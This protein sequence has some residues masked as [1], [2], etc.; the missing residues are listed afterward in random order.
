VE[1]RTARPKSIIFDVLVFLFHQL[2]STIGVVAIAACIALSAVPLL[3]SLFGLVDYQ[4]VRSALTENHLYPVQMLFA[5]LGGFLIARHWRQRSMLWVWIL[6]AATLLVGFVV[7]AHHLS[8]GDRLA[9]FFG[10]GC[11]VR[12][13]CFDQ[14]VFTLPLY[15]AVVYSLG[16][17]FGLRGY[18]R[19]SFA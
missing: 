1:A 14:L 17:W 10:S 15:T 16:A 19:K 7:A 8:P 13:G 4:N 2:L 11:Q 3:K 9:H 6:P 5:L 12:S 18:N